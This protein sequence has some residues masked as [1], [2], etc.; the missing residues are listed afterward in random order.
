M[1]GLVQ[2][3]LFSLQSLQNIK[4]GQ[5]QDGER[6]ANGQGGEVVK[7]CLGAFSDA[8]MFWW[9]VVLAHYSS[10][11]EFLIA[12]YIWSPMSSKL[13]SSHNISGTSDSTIAWCKA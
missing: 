9:G 2:A 13:T 7:H 11:S 5:G 10:P 12:L 1:R 8:V 3:Y 6:Q 4:V